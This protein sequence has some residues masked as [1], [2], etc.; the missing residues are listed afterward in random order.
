MVRKGLK[1]WV[2]VGV[3]V[4]LEIR[5]FVVSDLGQAD[6]VWGAGKGGIRIGLG[7]N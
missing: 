7:L 4:W 6:S 5:R 2:L 3:F 1:S